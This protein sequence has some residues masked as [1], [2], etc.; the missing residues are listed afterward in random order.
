MKSVPPQ[1][2]PV[3]EL[4]RFEQRLVV[5]GQLEWIAGFFVSRRHLRLCF[6]GT[7]PGNDLYNSRSM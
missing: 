6:A 5:A 4:A 1:R 7:V 2:R 3:R